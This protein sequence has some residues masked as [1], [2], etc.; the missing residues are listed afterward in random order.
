M[1]T[2]SLL[3][4]M[5]NYNSYL[6]FHEMNQEDD[7][8]KGWTNN[9]YKSL[10][11]HIGLKDNQSILNDELP[12]ENMKN[13]SNI[14]IDAF[15]KELAVKMHEYEKGQV[16]TNFIQRLIHKLRML[17]NK[18]LHKANAE[19]ASGKIGFFKNI[20][21]V[22]AN[23]I[24]TFLAILSGRKTR[25]DK[26]SYDNYRTATSIWKSS[27]NSALSMDEMDRFLRKELRKTLN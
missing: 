22:I 26:I 27:A 18:W 20:L 5:Y 7:E 16:P 19:K 6:I 8:I 14:D 17:Y 2:G 12:L 15:N 10:N 23:W 1:Y 13:L 9:Y 25:L 11:T 3:E 4:T 24:D 21:R